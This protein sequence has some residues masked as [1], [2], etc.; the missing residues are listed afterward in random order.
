MESG[1]FI[2]NRSIAKIVELSDQ[3]RKEQERLE[4]ELEE[5]REYEKA[6]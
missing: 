2:N 5:K 1:S 3:Y 6:L 4:R